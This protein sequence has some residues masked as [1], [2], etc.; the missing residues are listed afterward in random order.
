MNNDQTPP[1]IETTPNRWLVKTTVDS[2]GGDNAKGQFV[3]K[4]T[5]E[6]IYGARQNVKANNSVTSSVIL[7][8]VHHKLH[9]PTAE[10]SIQAMAD[11]LNA[12]GYVPEVKK[13]APALAI[14]QSL[15]PPD[16]LREAIRYAPGYKAKRSRS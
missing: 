7:G 14:E 3:R 11:D 8:T 1:L 16:M 13:E 12:R 2:E 6:L 9:G 10:K 15:L 4:V 5:C